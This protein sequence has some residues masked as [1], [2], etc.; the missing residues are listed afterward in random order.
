[1]LA[2]QGIYSLI[3]FLLVNP[4]F[5]NDPQKICHYQH[6]QSQ[7][8]ATFEFEVYTMFLVA[9]LN[10]FL[11]GKIAPEVGRLFMTPFRKQVIS[12]MHHQVEKCAVVFNTA[13]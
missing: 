12:S 6:L 8:V 2:K 5:Q 7:K 10:L 1:M 11:L 13:V 4:E 9:S 3:L